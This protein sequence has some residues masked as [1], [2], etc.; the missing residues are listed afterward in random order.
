MLVSV[1]VISLLFFLQVLP[2]NQ[3]K[4]ISLLKEKAIEKITISK[5]DPKDFSALVR[6]LNVE[7]FKRYKK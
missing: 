1:K 7:Q 3:T 6:I 5:L 4:T 2:V